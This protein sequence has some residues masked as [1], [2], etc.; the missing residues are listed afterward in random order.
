MSFKQAFLVVAL[1]ALAQV[2]AQAIYDRYFRK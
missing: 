2:I 1:A